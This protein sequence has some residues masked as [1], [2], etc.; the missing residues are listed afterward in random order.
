MR[1]VLATIALCAVVVSVACQPRTATVVGEPMQPPHAARA[2]ENVQLA[3]EAFWCDASKTDGAVCDADRAHCESLAGGPCTRHE[4][5]ACARFKS[6]ATGEPHEA[7]LDL[8]K[9]C[10]WVANDLERLPDYIRVS[11]C[12]VFRVKPDRR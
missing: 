7:C 3:S 1:E 4:T 6:R 5:W 2:T 9:A 12:I 8:Y 11:E 10:V